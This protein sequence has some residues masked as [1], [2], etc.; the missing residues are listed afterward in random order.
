M[1]NKAEKGFR[2]IQIVDS[3]F[4]SS[5]Q[6][7]EGEGS[8]KLK[9]IAVI[10]VIFLIIL[11]LILLGIYLFSG[12]KTKRS[13][14]F[15]GSIFNG[16]KN[17][18]NYS[19]NLSNNFDNNNNENNEQN[20]EE[21]Y[22]I[23]KILKSVEKKVQKSDIKIPENVK[24][25]IIIM[26]N[27]KSREN[28]LGE[29][30]ESI[31]SQSFPDKEIILVKNDIQNNLTINSSEQLSKASATVEYKKDTGK[32]LQRY[33]IVNMAKG[34]YILFIEGDDDFK[35]NDVLSQIYNKASQDDVDI[36]EYK[37]Y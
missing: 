28:N 26:N 5:E 30:Y 11:F 22:D 7:Y 3:N 19:Y 8:N 1:Q 27:D 21:E 25:S 13:K 34:D 15:G 4:E 37:S 9:L 32:I 12:K 16:V 10:I 33:D 23:E 17:N 36:L 18:Y 31:E 14:R 35:E 2:K 20:A 6:L 29:L 24:I